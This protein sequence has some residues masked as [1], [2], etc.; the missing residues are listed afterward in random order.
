VGQHPDAY[1]LLEG[2]E[3]GASLAENLEELLLSGI[4][5]EILLGQVGNE[6]ANAA[7]LGL[8][9]LGLG[10]HRGENKG[11]HGED[12]GYGSHGWRR[13]VVESG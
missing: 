11:Q 4:I 7:E 6:G 10:S 3:N 13:F 8:L 2:R 5:L 12:D 9:S 1:L